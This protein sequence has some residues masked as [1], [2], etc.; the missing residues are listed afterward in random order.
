MV[1]IIFMKT[2]IMGLQVLISYHYSLMLRLLITFSPPRIIVQFLFL[3][4]S[5]MF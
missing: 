3:L 1:M 5:Q 2:L 4:A